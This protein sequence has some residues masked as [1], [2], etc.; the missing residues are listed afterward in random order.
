SRRGTLL[1]RPAGR[2][3]SRGRAGGAQRNA[4]S[5]SSGGLPSPS[6]GDGRWGRKG[7]AAPFGAHRRRHLAS[8]GASQSATSRR[9]S[10]RARGER[11]RGRLVRS[12]GQGGGRHGGGRASGSI[13][14]RS[15][16][17]A[18]RGGSGATG[19]HAHSPVLEAPRGG[20]RQRAVPDRLRP[21]ARFGGGSDGGAAFDGA[22]VESLRR[23]RRG[24]RAAGAAR[25]C[26]HLS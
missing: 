18:A 13:R 7:R 9:R 4:R 6:D 8:F 15:A 19:S 23:A 2:R 11:E 10:A 25:R 14:R 5:S 17:P 24:R 16:A 22:D 21:S 3:S 26:G 20:E 1:R 12:G